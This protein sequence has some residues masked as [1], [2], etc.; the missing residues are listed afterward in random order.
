[1]VLS[2]CTLYLALQE[3]VIGDKIQTVRLYV[4]EGEELPITCTSTEILVSFIFVFDGNFYNSRGEFLM[5]KL[6]GHTN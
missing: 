6:V 3:I 1:M 4:P 5:K 2:F